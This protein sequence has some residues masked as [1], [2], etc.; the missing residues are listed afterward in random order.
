MKCV[1]VTRR[2]ANAGSPGGAPEVPTKSPA[3]TPALEDDDAFVERFAHEVQRRW[4]GAELSLS[5][6]DLAS[7]DGRVSAGSEAVRERMES[8]LGDL[9]RRES[10]NEPKTPSPGNP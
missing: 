8:L 6:I 3:E 7:L 4:F 10:G 9:I 2:S 5:A 1:D